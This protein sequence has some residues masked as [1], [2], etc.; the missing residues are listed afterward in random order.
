M[1]EIEEKLVE[2]K[3]TEK[4]ATDENGEDQYRYVLIKYLIK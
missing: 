4:F 1:C 3:V 2:I